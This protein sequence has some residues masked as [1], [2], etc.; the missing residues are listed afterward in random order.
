[1]KRAIRAAAVAALVGGTLTIPA[2][3]AHA[4]PC[5][6]SSY[7]SGRVQ[8]VVYRNCGSTNSFRMRAW[9]DFGIWR[10]W[11]GCKIV[12]PYTSGVLHSKDDTPV[13]SRWGLE[14]C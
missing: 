14:G 10:T 13:M 1:M 5:G 6:A 2:S 3:P 11:G 8:Y 9:I 4:E 7:V 12:P